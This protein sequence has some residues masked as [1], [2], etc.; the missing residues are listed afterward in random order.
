MKLIE[1]SGVF[2]VHVQLRG[3]P[4]TLNQVRLWYLLQ[5]VDTFGDSVVPGITLLI[6]SKFLSPT[7]TSN[8][9]KLVLF[10]RVLTAVK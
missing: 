10:K 8:C 2:R 3:L 6:A 1:V 9:L 4:K 5:L 7:S